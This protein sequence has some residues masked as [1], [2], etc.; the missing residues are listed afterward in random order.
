[1]NADGGSSDNT[2]RHV[3]DANVPGNVEKIV[4]TYEGPSGKGMAIRAILEATVELD[5]RAC[6]IVE[7]R[8]PGIT[9]AWIPALIKPGACR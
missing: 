2:S 4:T 6:L 7:A 9:P 1:M 3:S 5:A 8:A